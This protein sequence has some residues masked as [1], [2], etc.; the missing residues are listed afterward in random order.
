M[1]IY[2]VLVG[3][4]LS[5]SGILGW[6]VGRMGRRWVIGFM[7]P[8]MALIL[9][10]VWTGYFPG[11]AFPWIPDPDL[12]AVSEPFLVEVSALFLLAAATPHVQHRRKQLG[13][14]LLAAAVS[15][16]AIVKALAYPMTDFSS[17]KNEVNRNGVTVQTSQWSCGPAAGA[18]ITRILG[19]ETTEKALARACPGSSI[20]GTT[21]F[22][23]RRGLTRILQKQ[24]FSTELI[25]E[26][27]SIDD[28]RNRATPFLAVT[29][30]SPLV[31]H[32]VVVIGADRERVKFADPADGAIE[33]LSNEA[34][35]RRWK[36]YILRFEGEPEQI[37]SGEDGEN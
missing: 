8:P 19:G 32:W 33:S 21:P 16:L 29:K 25:V 28:L 4:A 13:L 34:F 12:W 36:G 30:F 17:L 37:D 31:D 7:V 26:S 15:V 22:Q 10:R 3:A 1:W 14:G 23:M 18:T 27:L 2:P 20:T 35:N 24:G 9:F 6:L 5:A 11:L